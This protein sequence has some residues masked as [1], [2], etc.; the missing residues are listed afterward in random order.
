[1]YCHFLLVKFGGGFTLSQKDISY[2]QW[3]KPTN[4]KRSVT[5]KH[6]VIFVVQDINQEMIPILMTGFKKWA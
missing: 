4:A 5:K 1:M 3:R 2:F 6:G